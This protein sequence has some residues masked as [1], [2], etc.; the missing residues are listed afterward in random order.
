MLFIE[1][2][3]LREMANVG[4]IGSYVI[5]VNTNDSGKIP[6]FH[7]EDKANDFHTCIRIDKAEYFL[8]EGKRDILNSGMR[9]KL[10]KFLASKVSHSKYGNL[11]SNNW[12]LVC[13]LWDLNNSDVEIADDIEMPNY[14]LLREE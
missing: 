10:Q 11:F 3:D 14:R 7:M 8:H 6:H 9:K 1:Q 13:F 5:Y 12:E 4:S 2:Q